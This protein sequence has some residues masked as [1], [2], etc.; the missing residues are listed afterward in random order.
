M[1]K[2]VVIIAA[3]LLCLGITVVASCI[4]SHEFTDVATAVRTHMYPVQ[5]KT[6]FKLRFGPMMVLAANM[7]IKRATETPEVS[8]YLQEIRKVQV[9]IYEVK[10][11]HTPLQ[12]A[13]PPDEPEQIPFLIPFQ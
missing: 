1:K 2:I 10:Q 5:L 11:S 4:T 7:V 3:C 13:I 12:I 9:G 8:E 6:K